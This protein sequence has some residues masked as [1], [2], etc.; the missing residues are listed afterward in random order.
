M[1]NYKGFL[2]EVVV[3]VVSIVIGT[4]AVIAVASFFTVPADA[5]TTDAVTTNTVT[6]N[7]AT[8]GATAQNAKAVRYKTKV[9]VK[10]YS[11]GRK[12]V[13][14]YGRYT[15]EK[16]WTKRIV[17]EW[18]RGLTSGMLAE[19]I[20]A[21]AANAVLASAADKGWGADLKLVRRK[22]NDVVWEIKFSHKYCEHGKKMKKYSVSSV[23]A[24]Q[25]VRKDAKWHTVYYINGKQVD[26]KYS[27]DTL[28][29]K[30]RTSVNA[31]LGKYAPDIAWN[32]VAE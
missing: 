29:M 10:K 27:I 8:V 4:A 16:K 15:N 12:V 28:L 20:C 11:N 5:A 18:N 3:L 9:A 17:V 6:A 23:C 24:V 31:K 7:A 32:Y 19:R 13:T 1:S 2:K 26:S 22:A 14:L 30:Q 25:V 21:K